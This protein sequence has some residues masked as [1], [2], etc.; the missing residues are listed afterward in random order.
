MQRFV[1]QVPIVLSYTSACWL[2]NAQTHLEE[3]ELAA[4]IPSNGR[5]HVCAGHCVARYQP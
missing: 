2:S 5:A 1:K 3:R 4:L